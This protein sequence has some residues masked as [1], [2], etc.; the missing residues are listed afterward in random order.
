MASVLYLD[1][2]R[3]FLDGTADIGSVAVDFRA[4]AAAA[5]TAKSSVVD[6]GVGVVVDVV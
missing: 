1:S 5:A 2:D 3:L 6:L 4:A